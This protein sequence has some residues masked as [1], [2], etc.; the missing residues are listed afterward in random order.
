MDNDRV[1]KVSFNWECDLVLNN[2]C[3]SVKHILTE[4]GLQQNHE[5]KSMCDLN[6]I[7]MKLSAI[8][9]ANW[10]DNLYKK[11]QTNFLSKIMSLKS[12]NLRSYVAP[13]R[14]SVFPPHVEID[15]FNI[16]SRNESMCKICHSVDVEDGFNFLF[17]FCKKYDLRHIMY[18]KIKKQYA[19]LESKGLL[20][21]LQILSDCP[22][23]LGNYIQKV[24]SQHQRMFCIHSNV[25]NHLGHVVSKILK[26][27]PPELIVV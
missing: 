8:N 13:L 7:E 24:F 9:K 6:S 12:L 1:T 20:E 18:H 19:D 15:I 26:Q 16:K 25:Q 10:R 4:C 23:L 2:W 21:K 14:F 3:N 5:T 27:R 17:F 22:I 11:A